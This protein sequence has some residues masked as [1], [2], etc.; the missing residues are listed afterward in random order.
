LEEA[1]TEEPTASQVLIW[2]ST[3]AGHRINEGR[4]GL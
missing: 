4:W 3:T 1:P 2:G